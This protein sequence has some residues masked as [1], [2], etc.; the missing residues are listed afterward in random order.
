MTSPDKDAAATT[1][2]TLS[3]FSPCAT[4]TT[5][6]ADTTGDTRSSLTNLKTGGGSMKQNVQ[7]MNGLIVK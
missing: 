2:H 5:D 4:D 1:Q 6:T 7:K 3:Q